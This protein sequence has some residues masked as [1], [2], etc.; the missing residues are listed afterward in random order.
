MDHW[1]LLLTSPSNE[2]LENTPIA[3]L[4]FVA[5]DDPF[6]AS[7]NRSERGR[8]F[9]LGLIEFIPA[10]SGGLGATYVDSGPVRAGLFVA[11][12][13]LCAVVCWFLRHRTP[14]TRIYSSE[15]TRE[16]IP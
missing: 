7:L 13:L 12:L 16:S 11:G 1:F 8:M 6:T 3:R 2:T 9:W 5:P 10:L 15:R 14:L 4:N